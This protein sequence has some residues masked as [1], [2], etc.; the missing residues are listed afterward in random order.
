MY[1]APAVFLADEVAHAAPIV[2]PGAP[3]GD[4]TVNVN[5]GDGSFTNTNGQILGQ[6]SLT[7]NLPN[8]TVDPSAATFGTL[9][10]GSAF[11]LS[12]QAISN[13]GAW[14]LPGTAVTVTTTQGLTNAGTITVNDLTIDGALANQAGATVQAN[15]AFTLTGTGASTNA[16][17]VEATNTLNITGASYDN[18]NGSTLAGN[19]SSPAGSGNLD[20]NLTGDLTNAGGTLNVYAGG[21]LTVNAPI[22]YAQGVTGYSVINQDQGFKAFFGSTWAEIIA[23]DVGG[24][25][26]ADGL[27]TL[28]GD[29]VID[30]GYFAGARGV[31][32]TGGIT[33]VR[34]P[35]TTPVQLGEHL[36]LT[37]W[38]WR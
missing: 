18:S 34:A 17:T 32:A 22:T 11:D 21:N 36:G 35:T 15:D 31:S 9:N 10:G 5:G 30:G 29:G 38:W 26:T 25:F 13:S 27:V 2:D 16:G 14:V 33:T 12:A 1:F 24:G 37:T 6:N 19:S 8:Q 7:V 3:V 4:V 23:T 20:L 28:T